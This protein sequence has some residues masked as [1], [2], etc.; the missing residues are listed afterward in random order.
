MAK[1]QQ[2]KDKIFFSGKEAKHEHGTGFPVH[3][4]I[5]NTAIGCR[6]VSSRLITI[7]LGAVLFNITEVN[8]HTRTP[9]YDDNEVEEC[10]DQLQNVIDQTSKKDIVV[11]Q[12]HWNA[13]VDK[14]AHGNWQGICRPCGNDN[15]NERGP[16]LQKL[17]TFNDLELAN[18]FVHHK[19][20]RRWTWHSPNKQRHNQI[21][22]IL[23]RKNFRSG[24]NIAGARSFQGANT[25]S[26]HNL[27]MTTFHRRLKRISE[28][29]LTRLKFDLEKPKDPKVVET[30]QAMV[31][32]KFA[33]KQSHA[34]NR[35][36]QIEAA[37]GKD[38]R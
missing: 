4:N 14:D 18:T 26:D 23:V 22:Y 15:T 8:A 29:K 12:G 24:V 9:N 28:P 32:G 10:Y 36:E 34:E 37:S 6:Q 2:R 31:G 3:T 1:E 20:S 17:A 19:A 21:G 7:H 11:L 16:R 27:R 13:K 38:Y 5:V 35:T 25:G 33:P 30:F